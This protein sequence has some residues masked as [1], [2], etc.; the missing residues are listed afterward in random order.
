MDVYLK[1][2]CD[3][4]LIGLSEG[5]VFIGG[6]IVAQGHNRHILLNNPTSHEKI[7]TLLYAGVY[8]TS[9]YR[10]DTFYTTLPVRRACSGA[11]TLYKITHMVIDEKVNYP[12]SFN[13]FRTTEI[14]GTLFNNLDPITMIK[15]S[16]NPNT[17]I[18]RE[19]IAV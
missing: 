16:I 15:T 19:D 1:V 7:N 3:E 11:I 13:F 18:W 10:Q 17:M 5:R 4:T 12:E 9:F 6:L 8:P 2:G 14:E